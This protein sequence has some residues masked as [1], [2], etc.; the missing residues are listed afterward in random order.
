MFIPASDCHLNIRPT[1]CP[2][3]VGDL[4]AAQATVN[5]STSELLL[6]VASNPNIS[7]DEILVKLAALNVETTRSAELF[8]S[9]MATSIANHPSISSNSYPA[10]EK[11]DPIQ[12]EPLSKK[13]R[14]RETY[15][16]DSDFSIRMEHALQTLQKQ[17]GAKVRAVAKLYGVPKSTLSDWYHKGKPSSTGHV[18]QRALTQKQEEDLVK[19]IIALADAGVGIDRKTIIQRAAH[20][21]DNPSFKGSSGFFRNFIKRHPE[22][23]R[24]KAQAFN[25]R[26]LHSMSENNVREYFELLS[27]AIK[28]VER[29]SG[30][31]PLSADRVYNADESGFDQSNGSGYVFTLK[32]AKDVKLAVDGDRTRVSLASFIRA[33]GVALPPAFIFPG[34]WEPTDDIKSL[35][36]KDSGVFMT[37]N[38]YVTDEVR[39]LMLR[40]LR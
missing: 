39:L 13:Q 1:T 5:K 19:D 12:A 28:E 3:L 35:F 26:R 33:D 31:V 25:K 17:N 18:H 34:K 15:A 11:Q 22:L 16:A 9:V 36:I 29:L 30:G 37:D 2:S 6:E 10:D 7:R 24:R 20:I 27:S 4:G 14:V 8:Q 40:M 32:G 38:G 21:S 23:A